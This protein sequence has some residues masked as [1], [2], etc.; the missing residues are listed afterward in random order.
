MAQVV[1]RAQ[2]EGVRLTAGFLAA[3][4]RSESGK[5][6]VPVIDSARYVGLSR[7]G[8]ALSEA[9]RSPIIGVLAALKEGKAPQEALNLGLVRARRSAGFEAIQTP[10]DALLD[11]I[12]ENPRIEGFQRQVAGTC[13]AC[14]ALSGTDNM[15]THP[16]CVCF[17][18]PKVVGV[19]EAIAIPTG[20]DLFRSLTTQQQDQALGAEA[21]ELVR[22]GAPL[23]DFVSHSKQSE[24]DDLLTQAPVEDVPAA[25]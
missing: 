12:E 4:L 15:D 14:M 17:P 7:D 25:N 8:R 1:S 3:Y 6:T 10:R 19:R 18:V 13:G 23:Q 2:L 9:L 11:A 20:I 21:A 16:G 5:G 22:G 24:R